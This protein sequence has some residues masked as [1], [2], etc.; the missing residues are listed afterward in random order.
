LADAEPYGR[1]TAGAFCK[2]SNMILDTLSASAGI[3]AIYLDLLGAMITETTEDG[4]GELLRLIRNQ[5]GNDI[6]IVV[7]VYSESW[8]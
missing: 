6:P 2:I 4:E 3:D 5:V 1:V 8:V 7:R